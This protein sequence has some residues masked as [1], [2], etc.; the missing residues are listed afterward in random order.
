MRDASYAEPANAL[1]HGAH[2]SDLSDHVL[3]VLIPTAWLGA[4]TF[5]VAL[6]RAAARGDAPVLGRPEQPRDLD[7]R[8]RWTY[9]SARPRT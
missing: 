7:R 2:A 8:Y 5:L 1:D 6:G 4:V 9:H 3:Y